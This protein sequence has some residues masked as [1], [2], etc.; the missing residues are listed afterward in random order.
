MIDWEY[1][2]W[3]K[4]VE[5]EVGDVAILFG[6]YQSNDIC[7]NDDCGMIMKYDKDFVLIYKDGFDYLTDVFGD[8]RYMVKPTHPAFYV[9]TQWDKVMDKLEPYYIATKRYV[10]KEDLEEEL[11]YEIEFM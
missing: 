9:P 11:G 2:A 8:I 3:L 10:C 6:K 7:K 1:D 4:D 5:P